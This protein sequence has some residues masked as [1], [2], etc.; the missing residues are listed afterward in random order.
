MH[1]L[2]TISLSLLAKNAGK[3]MHLCTAQYTGRLRRLQVHCAGEMQ[4]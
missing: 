3:E 4:H 2:D 1:P